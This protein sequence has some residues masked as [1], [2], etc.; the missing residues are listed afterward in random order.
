LLFYYDVI[1]IPVIARLP[2]STFIM[3]DTA[4]ADIGFIG[5]AVIINK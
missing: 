1:F 5:L 2:Y 4:V 3:S